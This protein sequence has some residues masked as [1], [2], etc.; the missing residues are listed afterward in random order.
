VDPED[1]EYPEA[2]LTFTTGVRNGLINHAC[3]HVAYGPFATIGAG[4]DPASTFNSFDTPHTHYTINLPPSEAG[5][6]HVGYAYFFPNLTQSYFFLLRQPGSLQFEYAT[7]DQDAFVPKDFVL[8]AIEEVPP[9]CH[10]IK[11]VVDDPETGEPTFGTPMAGITHVV[12]VEMDEN[13]I[14]MVRFTS[15]DSVIYTIVESASSF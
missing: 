8:G 5:E 10:T 12:R 15:E 11:P 14:Y 9:A 4:P 1:A 13:E 3:G 6:P 2:E 7:V